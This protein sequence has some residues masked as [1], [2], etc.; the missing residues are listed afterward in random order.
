M[1][2]PHLLLRYA[3]ML[4]FA[5]SVVFGQ[6]APD[7]LL[8]GSSRFSAPLRVEVSLVM[9]KTRRSLDLS[10]RSTKAAVMIWV[11]TVF[12]FHDAFHVWRIVMLP[13]SKF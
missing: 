4:L 12:K 8:T 10:R 3:G 5:E 2:I 11:P 7:T 6:P 1:F 13:A 9:N